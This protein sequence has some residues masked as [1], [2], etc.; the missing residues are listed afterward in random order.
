MSDHAHKKNDDTPSIEELP[1]SLSFEITK[2]RPSYVPRHGKKVNGMRATG[3]VMGCPGRKHCVYGELCPVPIDDTPF[4]WTACAIELRRYEDL[5]QGLRI[6]ILEARV[7]P[8][9]VDPEWLEE[10]SEAFIEKQIFAERVRRYVA[11]MGLDYFSKEYL[12][13]PVVQRFKKRS[14]EQGMELRF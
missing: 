9:I 14:Q 4:N 1:L 5:A 8:K 12:E 10:L 7:R 11:G 6:W 2:K 13:D 3:P